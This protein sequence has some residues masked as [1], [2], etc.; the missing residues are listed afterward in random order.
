KHDIA[1]EEYFDLKASFNDMKFTPKVLHNC[2][3]V[4]RDKDY[5]DYIAHLINNFN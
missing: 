1:N 5:E 2:L 4:D 3:K